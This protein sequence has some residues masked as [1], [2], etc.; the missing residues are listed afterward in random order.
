MFPYFWD[1]TAI[2][3]AMGATYATLMRDDKGFQDLPEEVREA[4]E[5]RK[6]EIRTEEDLRRMANDL[7]LRK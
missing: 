3:G 6:G 2:S 1:G 4:I 5:A 7:M